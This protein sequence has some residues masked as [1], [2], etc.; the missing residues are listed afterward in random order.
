M[1]KGAR[2]FSFFQANRSI[3]EGRYFG[4][5]VPM[6]GSIAQVQA[7]LP[8]ESISAIMSNGRQTGI[9][10]NAFVEVLQ[11]LKSNRIPILEFGWQVFYKIRRGNT[12][13]TGGG[14]RQTPTLPV[15]TNVASDARF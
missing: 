4:S 5:E 13:T 14:S 3:N 2:V 15:L 8:G 11:D 9:F 6:V 7:T 12:G 1:A 10:T